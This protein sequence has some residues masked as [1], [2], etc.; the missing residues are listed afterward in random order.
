MSFMMHPPRSFMTI[1]FAAGWCFYLRAVRKRTHRKLKFSC[2]R[3]HAADTL[4][5]IAASPPYGNRG[6]M[7]ASC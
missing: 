5:R 6:H 7:H 1:A 2:L 3:K 4:W